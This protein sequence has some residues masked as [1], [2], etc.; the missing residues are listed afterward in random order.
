LKTGFSLDRFNKSI[1]V[2][3]E[4]IRAGEDEQ[5]KHASGADEDGFSDNAVGTESESHAL[6]TKCSR[7]LGFLLISAK[8]KI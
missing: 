8:I 4:F 6:K 5:Q 2:K 7:F 1:R 3:L